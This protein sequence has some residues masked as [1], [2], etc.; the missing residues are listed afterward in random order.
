MNFLKRMRP[1]NLVLVAAT[2]FIVALS[3]SDLVPPEGP[4]PSVEA[5]GALS[6]LNFSSVA[7]QGLDPLKEALWKASQ[8]VVAEERAFAH[9]HLETVF[10]GWVVTARDLHAA[11]EVEMMSQ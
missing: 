6:V 4:I 9:H 8:A 2:P 3:K 5:P 1:S 7:R 11:I 10:V